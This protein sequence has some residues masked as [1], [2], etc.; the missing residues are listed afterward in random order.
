MDP[1]MLLK[2]AVYIGVAVLIFAMVTGLDEVISKFAS[3][4]PT[5]KDLCAKV[6]ELE[7]RVE[8]LENSKKQ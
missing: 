8:A 1:S 4:S 5:K 6:K 7:M 3:G 2:W